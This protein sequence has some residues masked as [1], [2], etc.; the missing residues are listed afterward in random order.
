M[1]TAAEVCGFHEMC[2]DIGALMLISI[3]FSEDALSYI[4]LFT[5]PLI[6]L[7]FVFI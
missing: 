3:C 5:Q 7:A 6:I 2:I 4:H 1:L